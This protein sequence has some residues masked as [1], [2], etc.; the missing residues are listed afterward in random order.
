MGN[1]EPSP[2][3]THGVAWPRPDWLDELAPADLQGLNQLVAASHWNQTADDWRL[4]MAFGR[5]AVIRD[6]AGQ[7]IAS[8]AVLPMETGVRAAMPAWISMILVHPNHRDRGLG[9]AVFR[10]CLDHALDQGYIPML[11][12]TPQ[13]AALYQRHG[14]RPL[15]PLSRWERAGQTPGIA[16]PASALQPEQDGLALESLERAALGLSRRHVLQHLLDRPG[17]HC[18]QQAHGFAIVR[19]GRLA[20]H[21]GPIVSMAPEQD[22]ALLA[23]VIDTPFRLFIDVPDCQSVLQQQL[24]QAGFSRQRGFIRMAGPSPTPWPKAA[25]PALL[26]IAGPEYG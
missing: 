12:A 6:V 26:A 11:D 19:S 16:Q 5:I 24:R 22:S 10:H 25:A 13:G 20:M 21:A 18:I 7:V 9:S 1:T 4:F 15:W 17:S 2:L 8:G 3:T 23:Q 14:F